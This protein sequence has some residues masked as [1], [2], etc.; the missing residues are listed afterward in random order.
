MLKWD[1][2]GLNLA[3]ASDV[4]DI[5]TGIDSENED[6]VT[7]EQS[8]PDTD[9]VVMESHEGEKPDEPEEEEETELQLETILD[10]EEPSDENVEDDVSTPPAVAEAPEPKED[11]TDEDEIDTTVEDVSS[12]S[13]DSLSESDIDEIFADTE[14]DEPSEEVDENTPDDSESDGTKEKKQV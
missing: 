9:D 6:S 10:N 14:S 2:D 13:D 12:T 8:I 5:S 4:E 7:V 1:G 3:D 11:T